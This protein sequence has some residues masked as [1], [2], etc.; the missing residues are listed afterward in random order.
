MGLTLDSG[1]SSRLVVTLVLGPHPAT[2]T[3]PD[4]ADM[5]VLAPPRRSLP[6]SPRPAG[7]PVPGT[8]AAAPPCCEWREMTR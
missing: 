6:Y 2:L 4:D 5:P 8:P 1:T 7:P 3:L